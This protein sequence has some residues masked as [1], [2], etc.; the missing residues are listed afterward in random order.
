[1]LR[2]GAAVVGGF[3]A[4]VVVATIGNLVLRAAW[5]RYAEV[6]VAMNFT[7]AMLLLRLLLGAVSALCAGFVA[8]WI[9]IGNGAAVK[10]LAGL[11]LV[12]FLPVHYTL[13]ERFPA[14]YHMI[15]LLSLV[16]MPILGASCYSSYVRSRRGR[17]ARTAG[18]GTDSAA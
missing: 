15:F 9:A 7:L 3:L 8:A 2:A 6:E 13:W 4:W 10:V 12:A 14:W 11:M 5:P 16:A 18:T 1:M 17:L